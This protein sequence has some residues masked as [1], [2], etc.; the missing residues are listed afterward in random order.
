MSRLCFPVTIT[1]DE[2]GFFLAKF[3]DISGAAT[4]GKTVEESLSDASDCL[5]E[6]LAAMMKHGEPIPVP[7]GKKKYMVS[8]SALIGAKTALYI[9][10]SR[11]LT[12]HSCN[13]SE[14]QILQTENGQNL[15]L[16]RV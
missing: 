7:S 2:T 6:A 14:I 3:P 4:D 5:D 12:V 11:V 15:H 10:F 1:K 16:G 9:L 13:F 8:P